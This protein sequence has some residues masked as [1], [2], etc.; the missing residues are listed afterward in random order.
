MA[1]L[2][3]SFLIFGLVLISSNNLIN[4]LHTDVQHHVFQLANEI[5]R[6]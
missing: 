2:D 1:E 4:L 3:K 5:K 6:F